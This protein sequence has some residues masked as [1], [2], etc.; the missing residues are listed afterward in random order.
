MREI[1]PK[2]ISGSVVLL[3]SLCIL[4]GSQVT[5]IFSYLNKIVSKEIAGPLEVVEYLLPVGVVAIQLLLMFFK[6]T[7]ETP[8]ALCA[9]SMEP[10]C[11]LEL[12]RIYP[13]IPRRTRELA[14]LLDLVQQ[15]FS[16]FVL[17]SASK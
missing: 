1:A 13:S 5:Y 15:A 7:E 11:V 12:S 8:K 2:E 6:F 10:E 3:Y 17:I 14:I 4:V 16:L 9:L